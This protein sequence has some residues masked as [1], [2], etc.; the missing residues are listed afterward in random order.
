MSIGENLKNTMNKV[1]GSVKEE[2]GK[3]IDNSELELK[4][5]LQKMEGAA[6]EKV[7][8]VKEDLTKK[9]EQM[10]EVAAGKINETI[11]KFTK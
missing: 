6:G 3:A 8:E 11:D 5:K 7:E 1:A 10:K 9:A 4:G 2:V